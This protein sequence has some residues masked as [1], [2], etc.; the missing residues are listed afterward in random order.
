MRGVALQR[1]LDLAAEEL[2]RSHAQLLALLAVDP[3][4]LLCG[5]IIILDLFL[6]SHDNK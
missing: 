5:I 2:G 6:R 1:L 3:Q 4:Q